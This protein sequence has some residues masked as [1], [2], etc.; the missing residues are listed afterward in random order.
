MSRP[1]EPFFPIVS[2]KGFQFLG[3]SLLYSPSGNSKGTRPAIRISV[4]GWR[5]ITCQRIILLLSHVLDQGV[6]PLSDD[7]PRGERSWVSTK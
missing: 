2:L 6:L 1:F 4:T 7:R 3:W 5:I